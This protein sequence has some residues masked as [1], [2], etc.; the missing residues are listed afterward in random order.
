MYYRQGKSREPV[1][2]GVPISTDTR[3]PPFIAQYNIYACIQQ[4]PALARALQIALHLDKRM[5]PMGLNRPFVVRLLQIRLDRLLMS[6]DFGL[7]PDCAV[8]FLT[9]TFQDTYE[10]METCVRFWRALPERARSL[11]QQ[12]CIR[13]TEPDHVARHRHG[14]RTGPRDANVKRR[15]W[16]DYLDQRL[17]QVCANALGHRVAEGVAVTCNR[18]FRRPASRGKG[19]RKSLRH[20]TSNWRIVVIW[21]LEDHRQLRR[22]SRCQQVHNEAA[23]VRLPNPHLA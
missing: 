3:I 14:S 21:I 2:G 22:H 23:L 20:P 19:L 12:C 7:E 15:E 6:V 18:S 8:E 13:P 10:A 11:A 9:F 5:I 1:A 4:L 16:F 17:A